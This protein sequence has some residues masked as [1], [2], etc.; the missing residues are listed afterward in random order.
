M[1]VTLLTDYYC[2]IFDQKWL[3]MRETILWNEV[4]RG[5]LFRSPI[6]FRR[7]HRLT[8][9]IS[10]M[11][12]MRGREREKKD[13][14]DLIVSLPPNI[15]VKRS[16]L[17]KDSYRGIQ[18]GWDAGRIAGKIFWVVSA[19]QILLPL[20]NNWCREKTIRLLRDVHSKKQLLSA[21]VRCNMLL[22]YSSPPIVAALLS[23]QMT[24]YVT[25]IYLE[26]VEF[27]STESGF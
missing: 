2:L 18:G 25:D 12:T 5:C 10:Q 22:H 7:S 24:H 16:S 17:M 13:T 15:E 11:T 1:D 6:Q 4:H 23:F 3:I 27:R 26:N 8:L 19:D 20:L 9:T 21:G 14:N